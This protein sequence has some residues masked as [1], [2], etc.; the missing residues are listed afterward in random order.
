MYCIS[1]YTML[2]MYIFVKRI[3]YFIKLAKLKI[4]NRTYFILLDKTVM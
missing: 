1:S 4:H 2:Y 3:D